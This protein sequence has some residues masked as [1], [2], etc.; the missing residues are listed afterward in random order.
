MAGTLE[1]HGVSKEI[2]A[3]V[4]V[5]DLSEK[6]HL[7]SES[8]VRQS[9]YR[10]KPYSQMFGAMKVADEVTVTFEAECPKMER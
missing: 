7:A 6:W 8:A 1:I 2:S 10:I 5:A 4:T 9:D 3:D